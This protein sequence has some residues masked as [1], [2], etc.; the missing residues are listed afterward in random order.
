[1]HTA[2]EWD[3][4]ISCGLPIHAL[5]VSTCCTV[6]TYCTCFC[7]L[8]LFLHALLVAT[9]CTYFSTL[10]SFLLAVLFPH[11]ALV[12]ARCTCFYTLYFLL[13]A[14]LISAC[15]TCYYTLYSFLLAVLF[16]HAALVI[17]RCANLCTIFVAH[18]YV[19]CVLWRIFRRACVQ[20]FSALFVVCHAQSLAATNPATG[21]RLIES[22]EFMFVSFNKLG[23]ASLICQRT[24]S[25]TLQWRLLCSDGDLTVINP[26]PNQPKP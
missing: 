11:A 23:C 4:S 24:E 16:P 6:S 2:G 13:H 18:L 1:M 9:R 21:S 5:L 8:Y 22:W 7:T 20:T 25:I 19:I 12:S 14:A 17:T 3:G 15:S 10:Y 26:N